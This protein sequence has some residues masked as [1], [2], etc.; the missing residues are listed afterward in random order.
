M[1]RAVRRA[2]REW[3]AE[4]SRN[5]QRLNTF[6]RIVLGVI[7]AMGLVWAARRWVLDP[8]QDQLTQ[9][10]KDNSVI[11]MPDGII[12][13]ENDVEIQDNE[14]KIENLKK[15]LTA[16]KDKVQ[17]V[18]VSANIVAPTA[19]GEVLTEMSQL[20]ARCRLLLRSHNEIQPEDETVSPVPVSHHAYSIT[21]PFNSIR[22]FIHELNRFRYLSSFDSFDI[23]VLQDD[24]HGI[25]RINGQICLQLN[26][27][28][29]QY[30]YS[31][32]R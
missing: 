16:S 5:W 26:F 18:A 19:K 22:T 17:S 27:V 3:K 11:D 12:R 4:F 23:Q 2:L 25:R 29:T 9:I 28:C 1:K 14:L 20:I 8:Q 7:I 32:G 24:E 6:M 31:G 10:R 15:S 30:Y 13:P 21:G